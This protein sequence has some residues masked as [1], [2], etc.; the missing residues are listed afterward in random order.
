[1]R[2]FIFFGL[3]QP[4]GSE[5]IWEKR[6]TIRNNPVEFFL[7]SK[8][9]FTD[10]YRSTLSLSFILK[11]FKDTNQFHFANFLSTRKLPT[12]A[13]HDLLHPTKKEEAENW[14]EWGRLASN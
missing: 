12:F 1:M 8:P 14:V 3:V 10:F 7:A 2:Y 5:I 13:L 6:G 9:V 11:N 4:F